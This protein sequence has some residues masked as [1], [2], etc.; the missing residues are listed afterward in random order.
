MYDYSKLLGKG[1][2]VGT[3]FTISF[4]V[5]GYFP[6]EK[7][8]EKHPPHEHMERGTSG[9]TASAYVTVTAPSSGIYGSTASTF[10]L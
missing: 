3:A 8:S 7:Q 2:L 10:K 1:V 5:P 4:Y 9:S 6:P